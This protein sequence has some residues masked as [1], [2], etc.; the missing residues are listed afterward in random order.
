MVQWLGRCA[1]LNGRSD[2]PFW[3]L[4]TFL[5]LGDV[6]EAAVILGR[7]GTTLGSQRLEATPL[8]VCSQRLK[9]PSWSNVRYVF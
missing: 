2:H 3:F 7:W 8:L 5:A 1:D 9:V 6:P 4:G